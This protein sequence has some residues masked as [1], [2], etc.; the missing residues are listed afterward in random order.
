VRADDYEGERSWASLLR[1]S[2]GDGV[3]LLDGEGD[4]AA[5]VEDFGAVA[6]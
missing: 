3:A 1:L 6:V 5:G 2:V 4:G